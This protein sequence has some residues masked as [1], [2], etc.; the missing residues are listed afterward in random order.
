MSLK[1]MYKL[2][3]DLSPLKESQRVQ[4]YTQKTIN[5][6][7]SDIGDILKDLYDEIDELNAEIDINSKKDNKKRIIEELGD[8]IFVLGN[9]ANKYGIDSEDALKHSIEEFKRRII[10]C[11]KHYN[12]DIK[13]I[14]NQEMLKLWKQAKDKN[15]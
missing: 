11:E 5:F 15:K 3:A 1:E 9:L 6:G 14:S 7:Y 12:G 2:F 8:V 10:Y 4:E 13:Q